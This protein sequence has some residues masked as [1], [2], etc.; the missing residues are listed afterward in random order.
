MLANL[1]VYKWA[2][3]FVYFLCTSEPNAR[4][5][6]RL[7]HVF[8]SWPNTLYESELTTLCTCWPIPSWTSGLTICEQVGWTFCILVGWPFCVQIGRPCGPTP[9]STIGLSTVYSTYRPTPSCASALALLGASGPMSLHT[10][11][12]TLLCLCG[13]NFLCLRGPSPLFRSGLTPNVALA[14][15]S[16]Y[17]CAYSL[18]TSGLTSF[19]L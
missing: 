19:T 14:Y 3:R 16:V 11:G 15:C 5:A 18:C 4:C 10:N 2:D 7:A 9:P 12:P 8:S 13:P 17:M 1:S 6:S